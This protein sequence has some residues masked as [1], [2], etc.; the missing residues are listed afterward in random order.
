MHH[1]LI[2]EGLLYQSNYQSN[3]SFGSRCLPRLRTLCH[4]RSIIVYNAHKPISSVSILIFLPNKLFCQIMLWFHGVWWDSGNALRTIMWFVCSHTIG[5]V[6]LNHCL[7]APINVTH[8]K[9]WLNASPLPQRGRMQIMD[10]VW[11][12]CGSAL[13]TIACTLGPC[14]VNY[15]KSLWPLEIKLSIMT[16]EFKD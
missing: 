8:R 12:N 2:F 3:C 14:F 4:I 7:V 1:S 11:W 10:G 6:V 9:R 13:R 5:G 16:Y 15:N